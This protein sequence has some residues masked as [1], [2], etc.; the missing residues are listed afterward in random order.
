MQIAGRVGVKT[1]LWMNVSS[2]WMNVGSFYL[3]FFFLAQSTFTGTRTETKETPA[4]VIGALV[5]LPPTART[6][7]LSTSQAVITRRKQSC[8]LALHNYNTFLTL[9]HLQLPRNHTGTHTY[10]TDAQHKQ[11]QHA[12]PL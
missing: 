11:K 6:K 8:E 4:Q 2:V 3:S 9:K 1:R 12:E 5:Q 10:C 7:A